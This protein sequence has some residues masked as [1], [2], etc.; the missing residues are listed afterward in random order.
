MMISRI[1]F[2]VDLGN[3]GYP[4]GLAMKVVAG[5]NKKRVGSAVQRAS[6]CWL[7]GHG[8][9]RSKAVSRKNK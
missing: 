1:N 9:V 8:G 7:G 4:F 2:C 6:N 3:T 5:R